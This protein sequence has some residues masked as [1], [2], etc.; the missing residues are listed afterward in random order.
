MPYHITFTILFLSFISICTSFILFSYYYIIKLNVMSSCLSCHVRLAPRNGGLAALE[1]QGRE[2]RWHL[3]RRL[4][5]CPGRA[6]HLSDF[7]TALKALW[8][9]IV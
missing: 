3:A 8:I 5:R 9:G 1:R 6:A 7:Y 2:V 4:S